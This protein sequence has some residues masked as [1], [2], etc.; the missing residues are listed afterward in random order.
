MRKQ[1]PE[2]CKTC[3]EPLTRE[4]AYKYNGYYHSKCKDCRNAYGRELYRK[5]AKAKK[6]QCGIRPLA[7]TS[8]SPKLLIHVT[9]VKV[10]GLYYEKNIERF[11]SYLKRKS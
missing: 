7:F 2:K 9:M 11:I 3:D 1:K 8:S 4:N 6:N 5:R 10:R